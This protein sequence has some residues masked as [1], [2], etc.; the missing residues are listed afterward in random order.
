MK[1]FL[2]FLDKYLIVYMINMINSLHPIAERKTHVQ[3]N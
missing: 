1:Y 2:N 3:F